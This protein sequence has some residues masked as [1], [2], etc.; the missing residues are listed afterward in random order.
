MTTTNRT[1]ILGGI[2]LFL[3]TV[4]V[5]V[6]AGAAFG[7]DGEDI[8]ESVTTTTTTVADD[9]STV[10][11]ATVDVF[12][13]IYV[14]PPLDDDAIAGLTGSADPDPS[15]LEPLPEG[16]EEPP[17]PAFPVEPNPIGQRERVIAS[18]AD[19]LPDPVDHCADDACRD[20]VGERRDDLD[21]A[22]DADRAVID[23]IL[24][25]IQDPADIELDDESPPDGADPCALAEAPDQCAADLAERLERLADLADATPEPVVGDPYTDPC[26]D[27]PVAPPAGDPTDPPPAGVEDPCTGIPGTVTLGDAVSIDVVGP[28]LHDQH[29]RLCADAA[30]LDDGERSLL[31]ATSV[32]VAISGTVQGLG[33]TGTQIGDPLTIVGA[34]ADDAVLVELPESIVGIGA[35]DTRPYLVTCLVV[36]VLDDGVATVDVRAGLSADGAAPRSVRAEVELPIRTLDGDSVPLSITGLRDALDAM[37][38]PG[39]RV[40]VTPLDVQRLDVRVDVTPDENAFVKMIPRDPARPDVSRCGQEPR[41]WQ[42]FSRSESR[43][44]RIFEPYTVEER[45]TVTRYETPYGTPADIC[46]DVETVFSPPDLVD[47]YEIPVVVPDPTRYEIAAGPVFAGDGSEVPDAMDVEFGSD[48][49]PLCRVYGVPMPSAAAPD[50]FVALCPGI[51]RPV[52]S[53]DLRLRGRYAD[54]AGEWSTSGQVFDASSCPDESSPCDALVMG[55]YAGPVGTSPEGLRIF[56]IRRSPVGVDEW[57]IG[58]IVS[59]SIEVVDTGPRLDLSR[60]RLS[61]NPDDRARSLVVDMYV[62]RPAEGEVVLQQVLSGPETRGGPILCSDGIARAWALTP[63]DGDPRHLRAVVTGLCPST[64]YTA[65]V[66]LTD[67]EGRQSRYD[68]RASVGAIALGGNGIARTQPLEIPV[69]IHFEVLDRQEYVGSDL[70]PAGLIPNHLMVNL[71]GTPISRY[72]QTHYGRAFYGLDC[73]DGAYFSTVTELTLSMGRIGSVNGGVDIDTWRPRWGG[74]FCPTPIQQRNRWE[75]LGGNYAARSDMTFTYDELMAGLAAGG[76]EMYFSFDTSVDA[77]P[78]ASA[79]DFRAIAVV[80]IVDPT[81]PPGVFRADPTVARAGG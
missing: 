11:T 21:A 3:L 70:Q 78:V 15:T 1:R 81:L 77:S 73:S 22:A 26:V 75:I 69:R 30:D 47:H 60:S 66:V 23:A 41:A 8:A 14:G 58:A 44:H 20:A 25:R 52:T 55:Y 37:G 72:F 27:G 35:G 68:S 65:R 63:V 10:T 67:A 64:E 59:E 18:A 46:V 39:R 74:N 42:R 34:T 71:N 45:F 12:E 28:Q 4:L 76:L 56:R 62:D 80:R 9:H 13:P 36:G 6:A 57:D 61:E 32:P 50:E 19:E 29:H 53:F 17:A 7:S 33:P 48:V 2:G 54:G 5:G 31:L 24:E 43:Q 38:E 79:D 40:R 51:P 16:V 49:G